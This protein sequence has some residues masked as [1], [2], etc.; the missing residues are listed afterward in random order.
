M[1]ADL[2]RDDATLVAG[3]TRWLTERY[4]AETLTLSDVVRPSAGYSSDTV[5]VDATWST[6]G[7]TR[8][9]PLVVRMPPDGAGTFPRYD[10]VPQLQAQLAAAEVGVPVPDPLVET[11]PAW[12]GTPFM[13]M[14]KVDGHIVGEVAHLDR[15]LRG[16]E[17]DDRGR[18]YVNF[19]ATVSAIHTA[20]PGPATEVPRR[21]NSAELRFWEEYLAWSSGGS[22]GPAPLSEALTWCRD[23]QPAREPA[24]TLLWG[25]VRFQNAIIGDDLSVRAVLDWDMTSVGAPEHDLAWFTGL[26]LTTESLFSARLDGFPD[27]AGTIALFEEHWGRPVQDLEWYETLAALKSTAILT[28][29]GYLRRDAG[30]PE[31]LPIDDNPILDLLKERIR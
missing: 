16:L 13:V 5:L 28:R 10:L 2:Q 26:A 22:P 7:T 15:W 6:G 27:R 20:D 29:I 3:L 18:I 21:D 4:G 11:D 23:H 12:I 19:V 24:P 17:L 1:I 25:D 14:Q 9:D 31:M 8:S 30:E